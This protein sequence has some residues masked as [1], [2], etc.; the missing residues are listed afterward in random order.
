MSWFDKVKD[1]GRSFFSL[2]KNALSFGRNA[3]G[4]VHQYAAKA[5]NVLN[6][7]LVRGLVKGASEYIPEI[8]SA[9]KEA[10]KLGHMTGNFG[11]M[12]QEYLSKSKKFMD[13][14]PKRGEHHITVERKPKRDKNKEDTVFGNIFEDNTLPEPAL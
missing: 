13:T 8:G 10:R 4:K 7:R 14:L 3:L 9:Y 1:F 2:G 6:N 5:N 11:R 12:G